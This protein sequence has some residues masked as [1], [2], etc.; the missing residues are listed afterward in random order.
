M[1][2]KKT[3]RSQTKYPALNSKLCKGSV[4]DFMD[5][6]YLES[7]SPS[8]KEFLN[9]FSNE[10]YSADFRG[11]KPLITGKKARRKIYKANNARNQDT[12]SY[13]G[14]FRRLE[15][16]EDLKD[17]ELNTGNQQE[18]ATIELL[19]LKLKSKKKAT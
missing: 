7:L 11:D 12:T 17:H 5:W 15:S 19:D 10:Y 1:A 4:R 18:D 16:F 2:K 9:K 14:N 8:E 13:L 3:K 6:D